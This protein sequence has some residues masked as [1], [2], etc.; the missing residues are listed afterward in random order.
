[1]FNGRMLAIVED[2][3]FRGQRKRRTFNRLDDLMDAPHS[4]WKENGLSVLL[5]LPN[6]KLVPLLKEP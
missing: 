1:M 3:H 6:K 5:Y 2:G 4:K